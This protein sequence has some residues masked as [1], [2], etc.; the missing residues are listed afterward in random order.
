MS[1]LSRVGAPCGLPAAMGSA[2]RAL[3]PVRSLAKSNWLP[4]G[5]QPMTTSLAGS[6]TTFVS[7]PPSTAMT[8]TSRCATASLAGKSQAM[9]LPSG[10]KNSLSGPRQS[11]V[12]STRSDRPHSEDADLSAVV[13]PTN[14]D[15]KP[16]SVGRPIERQNAT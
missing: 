3:D 13:F 7:V 6:T 10:E 11:T 2:H 16:F 14:T 5:D 12:F 8:N 1:G 4:S 9:Y 15:S